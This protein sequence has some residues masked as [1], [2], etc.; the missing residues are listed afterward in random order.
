MGMKMLRY[1]DDYIAAL[2]DK[3]AYLLDKSNY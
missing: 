1:D 3:E 2:P